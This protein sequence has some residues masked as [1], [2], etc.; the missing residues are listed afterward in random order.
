MKRRNTIQAPVV[1]LLSVFSVL[2]PLFVLIGCKENKVPTDLPEI[3][4]RY[5]ADKL[6]LGD[7]DKCQI[8]CFEPSGEMAFDH[9]SKIKYRGNTS[10]NYDKKSFTIKFRKENSVVGLP[11][12]RRWKL[13]AEYIDK[14]F[15][16][17]NLSYE[18]F[19]SFSKGNFAPQVKYGI[20]Y[21]NNQY[22]GIY[23]ITESVDEW[24][25]HLNLNDPGAVLFKGP[26][27]SNLPEDHD[28]LFRNF[29]QYS[30][31]SIRYDD[32][33][34]KARQKLIKRC[35]FNQRYP[36]IDKENRNSEIIALTEFIHNSSDEEFTNPEIFGKY[37]D[38]RN[39]IDW[40]LL[41]LITDNSDGLIKN[42]YLSRKNSDE[43]YLVT[44]WDYDHSF[45]RDG[46]GEPSEEKMVSLSRNR[47]ISRLLETN[48]F[49][50]RQNLYA[51][52]LTLEQKGILTTDHLYEIIDRQAEILRPSIK[53]NEK[54]WPLAAVH[55]FKGASFESELQRM[56]TWIKEHFPRVKQYLKELQELPK[57][58]I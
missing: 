19:R 22:Q 30:A 33:S 25:L 58:N 9:F 18:L 1:L 55:Y 26:P 23:A 38:I 48:G 42:F 34:Y 35:Y 10:F 6:N 49:D 52:F 3:Y 46:D 44:P 7:Y 56:K 50:Y 39:I 21:E 14:T 45:G 12:N 20:L 8:T 2:M 37:F 13:N 11:E 17:N 5:Y 28:S 43:P 51:K 57:E 54:R 16:R 47:L 53:D 31:I 24:T 4:I 32:F 41:I 15:I 36:G 40:H 27:I 29:Q